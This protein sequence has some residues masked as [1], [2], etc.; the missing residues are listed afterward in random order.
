[1]RPQHPIHMPEQYKSIHDYGIVGDLNTVALIAMDG[2][3][4]FLCL[5]DFDSPSV[6]AALLDH[7]KGG[8][9]SITPQL[10]D[11]RLKQMYL[12]D[13][14]ILMTRFLAD[15]AIVELIDFMPIGSEERDPA[16]IRMVRIVKGT[17]AFKLACL[18]RF[19]Y[20]R[21]PHSARQVD[22][23]NLEFKSE[24]SSDPLLRLSASVPLS[25]DGQDG[26]AE[27]CLETGQTAAFVLSCGGSDERHFEARPEAVRDHFDK[28]ADFW[29][30]WISQCTFSG[31]W[32]HIVNRSALVLK[33]LISRKY[34]SIVAAPTFG[35][36]EQVGGER[37]WDY[38]YTWIRDA[39]FTFDA[40][41]SLGFRSEGEAFGMW[42][43]DRLAGHD[44][45]SP[46][47]LQIMYRISGKKDLDEFSLDHLQGYRESKPVRIGNGAGT[48]FQLDIYGEMLNAIYMAYKTRDGIPYDRWK[49]IHDLVE[50]VGENWMRPDQGIWEVRGGPQNFLHSRLRCWVAIDRALR[51]SQLFSLPA[52]RE[53]WEK[54]R[55]DIYEDIFQNFWN[56]DLKAFTATEHGDWTDASA[57]LMPIAGIISSVDPRWLSTLKKIEEVLAEDTLVYRYDSSLNSSDGLSG[58]EG[59]F[60]A[61]SFWYVECLARAHQ[62]D[63]ARLLF[64]KMLSYANH[65]GLYSEELGPSGEH[66]GNFPQALSHLSLIGAA[67]CLNDAL[68]SRK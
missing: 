41:L 4:D 51:L 48:Q 16:L 33:L 45:S 58:K 17:A 9:F 20:A 36:P 50:W 39:A 27:F 42:M 18:P 5:P 8:R 28:T 21:T 62:L 3:L 68:E 12:P 15:E 23:C 60:T 24:N 38:R 26:A 35:L 64:E 29:R 46:S 32:R 40:F 13:T 56:P 61:C 30:N 44:S 47:P 25:I 31:R 43:Q 34:G 49:L 54:L 14:N 7:E 37:N 67:L 2:S 66:L 6:F 52:P 55:S 59:T 57:L 19:D 22:G 10:P 65:L 63:K 53:H 11:C 1:M